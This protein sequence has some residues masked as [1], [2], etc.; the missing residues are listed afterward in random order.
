MS[1]ALCINE[2]LLSKLIK[3]LDDVALVNAQSIMDQALRVISAPSRPAL[4]PASIEEKLFV[5]N[6]DASHRYEYWLTAITFASAFTLK[7]KSNTSHKSRT[8][9]WLSL[10]SSTH[11]SPTLSPSSFDIQTSLAKLVDIFELDE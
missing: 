1:L 8:P 6:V 3:Q 7:F 5:P 10:S 9:H 11:W 4:M 2:S